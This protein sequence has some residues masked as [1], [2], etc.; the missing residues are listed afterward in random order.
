LPVLKPGGVLGLTSWGFD[1]GLPGADIWAE[2]LE[3]AGAAPDPRDPSV[4]R[5]A[6]MDTV[7]KL[8]DLLV[9]ARELD[10]LHQ[11][12]VQIA[13]H[14]LEDLAP[15]EDRLIAR[16]DAARARA[17]VHEEGDHAKHRAR[18]VEA[19]IETPSPHPRILEGGRDRAKRFFRQPRVGMEEQEDVTPRRPGPRVHLARATARAR[20]EANTGEARGHLHGRVVAAPVDD[21]HL[22]AFGTGEKI[23]EE[24]LEAVGLVECGDDDADQEETRAVSLTLQS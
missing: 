24:A 4:M 2:E 1:P 11:R 8:G 21:N 9:A 3:Q 16:R 23:G 13:A 15:D 19:D 6:L 7:L 14:R 17:Q 10:V 20:E 12:H 18:A 22:G 5:Q